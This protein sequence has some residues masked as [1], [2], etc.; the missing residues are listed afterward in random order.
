MSKFVISCGGTGGHLAPGI[1]IGEAL[2]AAGNEVVF[3]I[4]QKGI[5][6]QLMQKYAGFKVVKTP[7]APFSLSPI[8][9]LKFLYNQTKSVCYMIKLLRSEKCDV[10]ISFGG[11]TALGLS[12]AAA[13]LKVPLVLHEAN[14]KAGKAIKF[15]NRFARRIYVPHG[16]NIS[17][18]RSGIIKHAGYPIRQEI[19][20]LPAEDSKEFFGFK[21]SANI[22]LIL[23]GSQGAIALNGWAA[24]NFDELARHNI[25]VLCICGPGK[26]RYSGAEGMGSDGRMHKIKYLPF[27]DNMSAALSCATLAIAR[28]GAGTIAEFARCRLPSILVP[29]PH[30][31]D[32][33][34]LE[35]AKCFEKQ[36]ASILVEQKDLGSLLNEAVAMMHNK[37]LRHAMLKNLERVDYLNDMNKIVSD[38][39]FIANNSE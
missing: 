30:S 22:L 10:A 6:S 15:L 12:V 32:N 39:N 38:L 24:D 2:L 13:I 1:A 9:F 11:F 25:D 14:R 33:H 5:D 26:T 18:R 27:C 17:R 7:G 37:K 23:G 20:K 31:A 28:A 19:K 16:V 4:S 21:R 34:Q 3:V 36:G 35:N 29:Y 8:R